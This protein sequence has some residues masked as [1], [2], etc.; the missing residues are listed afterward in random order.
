MINDGMVGVRAAALAEKSNARRNL[1]AWM[2]AGKRA[3]IEKIW[4][5]E[6]I[7]SLVGCM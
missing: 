4:T 2:K 6:T 1:G 5:W 7:R 3:R